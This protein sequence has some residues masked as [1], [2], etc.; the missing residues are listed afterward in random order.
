[1]LSPHVEICGW[2]KFCDL[3][4]TTLYREKIIEYTLKLSNWQ[5]VMFLHATIGQAGRKVVILIGKLAQFT[6]IQSHVR[7]HLKAS[8]IVPNSFHYHKFSGC[9]DMS[10]IRQ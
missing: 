9:L 4:L 10:D 5:L 7:R 6:W 8:Y 3:S 1:M 2:G